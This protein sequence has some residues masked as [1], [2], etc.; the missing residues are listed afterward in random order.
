[1]AIPDDNLP[2]GRYEF[3]PHDPTT[4]VHHTDLSGWMNIDPV[5]TARL[6]RIERMLERILTHL[7]LEQ[8][9]S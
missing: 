1:M 4:T 6:L 7:N 5:I 8:E 9:E 2:L 3:F